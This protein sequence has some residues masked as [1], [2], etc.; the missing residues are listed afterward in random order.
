MPKTNAPS[1]LCVLYQIGILIQKKNKLDT[2]LPSYYKG[3]G[4]MPASCLMNDLWKVCL[5]LIYKFNYGN[6]Q[7]TDAGSKSQDICQELTVTTSHTEAS[8]SEILRIFWN[9]TIVGWYM[10][11]SSIEAKLS[12]HDCFI[13]NISEMD[14][15]KQT[16][17]SCK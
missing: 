4:Y 3:R 2:S 10:L 14:C 16:E 9:T 12:P 6:F 11:Y 8:S 15:S 5:Y 7:K 17:I 1:N 13:M